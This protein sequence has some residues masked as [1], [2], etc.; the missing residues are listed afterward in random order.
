[1]SKKSKSVPYFISLFFGTLVI[2]ILLVIKYKQADNST[3]FT[4][5]EIKTEDSICGIDISRYQP[6]INWEKV[7][8]QI[9]F[10]FIRATSGRNYVDNLFDVHYM[11]AKNHDL[12]IG[13]YHYFVFNVNGKDQAVNFLNKVNDYEFD[14]PLVIDVEEHPKYGK[15]SFDYQTTI[16]NLRE[17]IT[18]VEKETK[19]EV[20]IYTNTKGYERYIKRNF[21]NHSLWISS[22]KSK[23]THPSQ[24]VFWQKTHTGK[25]D[26]TTDYVDINVFNGDEKTWNNYLEKRKK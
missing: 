3:L 12:P 11:N 24:W 4:L 21:P 8:P 15:P 5:N 1:M 7:A 17:F 14:L 10:V 9:D 16:N 23:E 19:T 26:G 13:A 20:L 22:F 6:H 18:K 25:I 2:V